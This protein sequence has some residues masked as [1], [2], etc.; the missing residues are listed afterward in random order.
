M[1]LHG[2]RTTQIRALSTGTRRIAELACLVALEPELLLLDEP[3][4]GI[5][6]RESEALAGVLARIKDELALTLV[7]I[8]HDL[9]LVFGI[10][11]RVLAMES[12]RVI[13]VGTPE[14]IRADPQVVRSYL[15]GDVVDVQGGEL[16]GTG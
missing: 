3:T 14:E 15:G 16:V 2:Y 8:E 13:A 6:Q 1:G 9:P 7:V 11:D 12:G 5:A 4:S 10:S